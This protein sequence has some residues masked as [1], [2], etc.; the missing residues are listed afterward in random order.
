VV[1]STDDATPDDSR[2]LADDILA[3]N[4]VFICRLQGRRAGQYRRLR[5]Q[6]QQETRTQ[7]IAS[8]QEAA[9]DR[10][11]DT[12]NEGESIPE[13]ETETID[14]TMDGLC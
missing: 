8:S 9:N 1:F 13:R 5:R 11:G 12:V 6:Q 3:I 14:E 2:E 4:T 7:E 10:H